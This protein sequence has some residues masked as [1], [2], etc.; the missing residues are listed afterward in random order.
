MKNGLM[1]MNIINIYIIFKCNI[2]KIEK[3]LYSFKTMNIL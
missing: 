2:L 3:K 1:I